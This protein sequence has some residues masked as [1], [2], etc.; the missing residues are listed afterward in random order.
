MKPIAKTKTP[1]ATTKPAPTDAELKAEYGYAW[2]PQI[3]VAIAQKRM[4][5]I[6]DHKADVTRTIAVGGGLLSRADIETAKKTWVKVRCA[7]PLKADEHVFLGAV[8]V[9][10][11]LANAYVHAVDGE[12]AWIGCLSGHAV[13]I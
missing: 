5:F 8:G 10:H 3:A 6:H 7:I 2:P 12:Y 4:L 13:E 9:R 1:K 11:E